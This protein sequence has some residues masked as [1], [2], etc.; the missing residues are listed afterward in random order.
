MCWCIRQLLI[1]QWG[2]QRRGLADGA[3][4]PQLHMT[5]TQATAACVQPGVPA[6]VLPPPC[7][8]AAS[9]SS[10]VMEATPTPAGVAM[11]ST[12]ARGPPSTCAGRIGHTH[13]AAS[14][15][16]RPLGWWLL[17]PCARSSLSVQHPVLDLPGGG[18]GTPPKAPACVADRPPSLN[19]TLQPCCWPCWAGCRAPGRPKGGRGEGMPTLLGQCAM[20]RQ[21]ARGRQGQADGLCC[22]LAWTNTAMRG[23]GDASSRNSPAVLPATGV[24]AAGARPSPRAHTTARRPLQGIQRCRS[25]GARPVGAPAHQLVQ[26][27][28]CNQ[29]G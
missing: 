15:W 1:E 20:R 19:L 8:H 25:V 17:Q 23:A 11:C 27:S 6:C 29:G 21:A 5:C 9:T 28:C 2:C 13:A 26:G 3:C 4:G 24:A 12:R 10:G 18:G 7:L 22:L 16:Q 14:R